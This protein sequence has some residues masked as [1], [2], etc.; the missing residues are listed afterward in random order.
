MRSITDCSTNGAAFFAGAG[1]AP[2]PGVPSK[3]DETKVPQPV[4]GR[5]VRLHVKPGDRVQVTDLL[6]ILDAVE[7]E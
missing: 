4:G 1:H 5:G 2:K 7:M 3:A 6:L